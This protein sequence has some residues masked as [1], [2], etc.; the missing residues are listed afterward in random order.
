MMSAASWVAS[1]VAVR[2]F[3]VSSHEMSK[4]TCASSGFGEGAGDDPDLV[5]DGVD[6]PPEPEVRPDDGGLGV[7]EQELR[8]CRAR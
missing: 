5:L 3:A 6:D 8:D 2:Y 4:E 1:G 7:A